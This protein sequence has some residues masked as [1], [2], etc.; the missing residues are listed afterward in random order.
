MGRS[1]PP[2]EPYGSRLKAAGLTLQHALASLSTRGKQRTVGGAGHA[3]QYDPGAVLEALVEV[4]AMVETG[5][6]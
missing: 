1:D 2:P 4:K 5:A 3:I 6:G